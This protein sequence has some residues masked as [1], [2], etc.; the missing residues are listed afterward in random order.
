MKIQRLLESDDK[1]AVFLVDAQSPDIRR[2]RWNQLLGYLAKQLLHI[3]STTPI[4]DFDELNATHNFGD[5]IDTF[6]SYEKWDRV[7]IAFD[8]IEWITPGIARDSHWNEEYLEFWQVIR[9]VQT[10]TPGFSVILAGVNPSIVEVS[11]FGLHQNPLFGIVT[12][13]FLGG[14]E[15]E[16]TSELIRKIGKIMGLNFNEDAIDFIYAQYA[17]HPLLT[18][19]ACSNVAELAKANKEKFPFKVSRSRLQHD[20]S[21]RDSELVFYVHHVVDEL[22]RFY[23]D[24]YKLLEILSVGEYQEFRM[25]I[26]GNQSGV[27][28]FRYGIVSDPE[29]P[30]IT[31]DV[32]QDFVANENVRREGRT[33]KYR[34][35]K[36]EDREQFLQLRMKDIVDDIRDL[37]KLAILVGKPSLYG[38]NSFPEAEKLFSIQYV[39]DQNSLGSALT[40]LHRCF[41]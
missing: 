16:E 23:P 33:W 32:V 27:H 12:P 34:I 11:R 22:E 17:G 13:L 24:E 6:L 41:V 3:V 21:L 5:S 9:T 40:T 25:A 19:L 2:R 14:L 29:Y 37:E 4:G 36:K 20:Q 39:I 18:R 26:R 7:T 31:Y 35:I 28:L 30:H 8:E 38:S 10:R 1:H 15:S